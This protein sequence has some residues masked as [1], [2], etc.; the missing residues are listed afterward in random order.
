MTTLVN[1]CE[2]SKLLGCSIT[3][4]NV[5]DKELKVLLL[6][7]LQDKDNPHEVTL[8]QLDFKFNIIELTGTANLIGDVNDDGIVDIR[9]LNLI[10]EEIKKSKEDQDLSIFDLNGDGKVSTADVQVVINNFNSTKKIILDR[11]PYSEIDPEFYNYTLIKLSLD[12]NIIYIPLHKSENNEFIGIGFSK[13][14]IITFYTIV[15]SENEAQCKQV[16]FPRYLTDLMENE[17]SIHV[18]Q[19][20]K[21]SWVTT[22]KNQTING[23]KVFTGESTFRGDIVID[24]C[25]IQLDAPSHLVWSNNEGLNEDN[26]KDEFLSKAN[27]Q[28]SNSY[29]KVNGNISGG[30]TLER[31]IAKL[32]GKSSVEIIN[33]MNYLQSGSTFE[34]MDDGAKVNITTAIINAYRNNKQPILTYEE[35]Q[36]K[37]AIPIYFMTPINLLDYGATWSGNAI[38][39]QQHIESMEYMVPNKMFYISGNQHQILIT[40]IYTLN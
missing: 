35:T 8:D 2:D 10:V 39:V 13:T 22:T 26:L 29:T 38:A 5:S 32:D 1:K 23:N 9:D 31:A 16:T 18:T 28:L 12:E 4:S 30:D 25:D 15:I 11:N 17:D 36:T 3:P 6:S 34:N 27:N 19:D 37:V 20:D 7:H 21:D 33:A 24:N 14:N 40:H